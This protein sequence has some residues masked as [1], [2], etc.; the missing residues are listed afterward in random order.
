MATHSIILAWELHGQ[1][2]LVG[3]SPCGRKKSDTTEPTRGCLEDNMS[4]PMRKMLENSQV[5]A[6]GLLQR[7]SGQAGAQSGGDHSPAAVVSGHGPS[8]IQN[9]QP[10]LLLSSMLLLLLLSQFS[11]V[12]LCAT[13]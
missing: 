2:S 10:Y 9:E 7:G 4:Q 8:S 11:H 1:K 5:P 13:P 6:C 3:Y 12:Q